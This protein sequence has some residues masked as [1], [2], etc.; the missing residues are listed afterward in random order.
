MSRALQLTGQ[1]LD[2][3]LVRP[4]LVAFGERFAARYGAGP[5]QARVSRDVLV[6]MI[7]QARDEAEQMLRVEALGRGGGRRGPCSRAELEEE[8]TEFW[9]PHVW[10]SPDR[11]GASEEV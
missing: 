4:C 5:P 8:M 3:A 11:A 6:D 7:C 2:I 10:E 9:T 1:S